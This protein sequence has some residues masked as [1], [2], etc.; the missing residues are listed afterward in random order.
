MHIKTPD[1]CKGEK[2]IVGRCQPERSRSKYFQHE[3]ISR[4]E[5]PRRN[6]VLEAPDQESLKSEQ[7]ANR[8]KKAKQKPKLAKVNYGRASERERGNQPTEQ[9]ALAST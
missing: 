7:P 8:D 6:R 5:Q 2:H 4:S 1:R 3:K 9:I